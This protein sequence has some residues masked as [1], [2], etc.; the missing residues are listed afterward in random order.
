MSGTE[1]V[2]QVN[3]EIARAVT[4]IGLVVAVGCEPQRAM[5]V[6]GPKSQSSTLE[7][8]DQLAPFYGVDNPNRIAGRF[9]VRF[10]PG[11]DVSAT[12]AEIAREHRIKVLHVFRAL[13]GFWG[14]VPD[15]A[16]EELR[17]DRRVKSIEAD[18]SMEISGV[19][20]TTQFGSVNSDLDRM[21]QRNLPLNG[22]YEWSTTGAGVRI[23]IVDNGVNKADTS[24]IGRVDTTLFIDPDNQ[25]PFVNCGP[26]SNGIDNHGTL[27]A[28][29]AAGTRTGPARKA[30]INVARV[31]ST[32]CKDISMGAAS[33]AIELIALVSPRPAVINYS[34][35]GNCF[36]P[37][38]GPT[39]DDAVEFAYAAGITVVVSAGNGSAPACTYTPAHVGVAITVAGSNPVNDVHNSSSNFG[40]CVD[41]Y[42]ASEALGT[43]GAA[44]RV[45]GVAALHLQLYPAYTPANVASVI[46]ASA[47]SGALAVPP[48]SPNLLLYSRRPTFNATIAGPS[49]VGPYSSCSWTAEKSGGQPPYSVQWKRDGV[50]VST[51]DTYSVFPAGFSGFLLEMT[52]VDGVG[53]TVFT[54]KSIYIDPSDPSFVCTP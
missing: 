49:T 47:T 21:D 11:V 40:S 50:L 19:G 52:A 25:G 31:N 53:R 14:E 18:I 13:G 51:G 17:R 42:A 29:A 37:L 27:M 33:A 5:E 39:V 45:S 41:L 4:V 35:A 20:D 16:I 15:Q 2:R 6:G 26:A 46:L 8:A 24:I 44:A 32:Q 54:P 23:W 7:R 38:C 48:G 22:T 1:R 34:S 43:S 12:V 28:V 10:A 9:I 3:K 36:G 30:T